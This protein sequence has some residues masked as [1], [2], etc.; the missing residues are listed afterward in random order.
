MRDYIVDDY[1]CVQDV[2]DVEDPMKKDKNTRI[3]R[4]YKAK[5]WTKLVFAVFFLIL[6]VF[7]IAYSTIMSLYDSDGYALNYFQN[8]EAQVMK[9]TPEYISERKQYN[10]L[11]DEFAKEYLKDHKYDTVYG[12]R[13]DFDEA[14]VYGYVQGRR[15][16][17]DIDSI[18]IYSNV[19]YGHFYSD[20]G[21]TVLAG[22]YPSSQD[23]VA[24]TDS[25][26][27]MYQYYGYNSNGTKV[28]IFDYDDMIGK[29]IYGRKVVG[30]INTGIKPLDVRYI[31]SLN[32]NEKEKYFTS[33]DYLIYRDSIH[34]SLF[35]T[36]QGFKKFYIDGEVR[37][38]A[39]GE[40]LYTY[41]Y[42]FKSDVDIDLLGGRMPNTKK[43]VVVPL[44]LFDKVLSSQ[45]GENYYYMTNSEIANLVNDYD[46]K[47]QVSYRGGEYVS[48]ELLNMDIVGFYYKDR[49]NS[50]IVNDDFLDYFEVNTPLKSAYVLLNH[51]ETDLVFTHLRYDFQNNATSN[52]TTLVEG[53][54]FGEWNNIVIQEIVYLA[55]GLAIFFGIIAM[56]ILAGMY[57]STYKY[58]KLMDVK[59]DD[60]NFETSNFVLSPNLELLIT[61]ISAIV[62]G[63]L[64]SFGFGEIYD[65]YIPLSH[66]HW[67]IYG[68][69]AIPVMIIIAVS[70]LAC[71]F[72]FL[73]TK[74]K[75]GDRSTNDL[76]D[77]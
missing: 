75:Y 10:Q 36:E 35:V 16:Y 71:F 32:A 24:I 13:E 54:N 11:F 22:R 3:V 7:A 52:H 26:F 77:I 17:L 63:I 56:C 48:L 59:I 28:D 70:F 55:I 50:I 2:Q 30:V 44:A 29:T 64:A 33:G 49:M 38:G 66:P 41:S 1:A 4:K 58:N 25:I 65:M 27:N 6:M 43:E 76:I 31:D 14:N 47:L 53:E 57:K 73:S 60:P 12:I 37:A 8:T 21:F 5:L 18:T 42:D 67:M 39:P 45:Y 61:T 40:Y 9:L 72:P 62:L 46:V 20:L 69:K 51:D 15:Y 34:M 68:M 19:R 23:E 74:A